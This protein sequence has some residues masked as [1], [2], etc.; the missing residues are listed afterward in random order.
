LDTFGDRLRLERERLG[1]SQEA[2]GEIGG[3]KKLAQI[4]YEKGKRHPDAEYLAAI[5]AAGVDVLYVLTGQNSNRQASVGMTVSAP[6]SH[7]GTSRSNPPT[8]AGFSKS[9]SITAEV[10]EIDEELMRRIVTML[11]KSAKDAGRRWDSERLML[12]AVDV[13]K[14]LAKEPMVDDDKLERVLKLVIN[15]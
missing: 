15:R 2:L 10:A 11:A 14:F 13:Y 4:N 12:A 6:V 9:D 8:S 7:I 1:L 3:V 5:A